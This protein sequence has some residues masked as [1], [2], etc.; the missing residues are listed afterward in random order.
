VIYTSGSTGRPKG[1]M[2]EHRAIVNRLTW[3]QG[4]YGLGPDDVVLQKTPFSFDVSVWEIFWPLMAGA[5]LEIARPEGHKD[6]AY[7]RALIE[8][9]RVTTAH[10]VPSML[11]VFLEQPHRGTSALRRVVCSGEALQAGLA[12]RFHERL[13][14]VA[15][16]NL[17][18][19]TEAAVDVTAWTCPPEHEGSIIPIG[20]PIANTRMYVLDDRRQ[21]VPVGVRGELYIGGVQVG[22]GYLNQPGLTAERFVPD[23]FGASPGARMYKT[24]DLGRWRADGTIEYLGRNDFQVKIRGFRVELGEIEARLSQVP[25][26]GEVVVLAR[27]DGDDKRL[28]AYYAGE[29]GV[30]AL[31]EHAQA[32]LPQYMVPS[33]YVRVQRWPLTPNGKL[34]RKA[35]PAPD[36]EAYVSRDYQAPQGAVEETLARLWSDLLKVD[37]V[38]RHDDFFELGGHSLLAVNLV[39]EVRRAF[40]V[41]LELV[42][43][44][45]AGMLSR[46]ATAIDELLAQ[47]A[48]SHDLAGQ[49]QHSD[50]PVDATP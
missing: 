7:L 22:R 2:N 36:G 27:Q 12:R 19:P 44:F 25:D 23:P 20:R 42:V 39:A 26:A 40:D 28:V 46:Q 43:V 32:H 5:T 41:A 34:D 9:A 49:A 3:M 10:F 37:R 30:Q 50:T 18:G 47:R 1:A 35:L 45:E 11:Q 48:R 16:H 33:A 13:P 6:P 29:V 8:D 17:Y 4:A 14:G 15:L 24:G 31:R 21:P 38:G